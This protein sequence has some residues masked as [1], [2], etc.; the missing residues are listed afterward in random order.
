M[1]A[2]CFYECL[3][4]L[5]SQQELPKTHELE[6]KIQNRISHRIFFLEDGLLAPGREG[7]AFAPSAAAFSFSLAF[8]C[9]ACG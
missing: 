1:A 8:A 9:A 5:W 6:P 2:Q 3:L 7:D 4:L